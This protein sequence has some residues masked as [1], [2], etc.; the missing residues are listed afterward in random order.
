M[1]HILSFPFDCKTHASGTLSIN[2]MFRR[3]PC[4]GVSL[5]IAGRHAQPLI[6][7]GR[8]SSRAQLQLR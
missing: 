3:V 5:V 2:D 4:A 1:A 7:I 6:I 8:R